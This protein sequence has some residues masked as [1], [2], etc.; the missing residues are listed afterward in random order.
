[1]ADKNI[2]IVKVDPTGFFLQSEENT[3]N[4]DISDESSVS[5]I[6]SG[7]TAESEKLNHLPLVNPNVSVTKEEVKMEPVTPP[8]ISVKTQEDLTQASNYLSTKPESSSNLP[9]NNNTPNS[10]K[11][12][13]TETTETMSINSDTDTD[14]TSSSGDDVI[15][16]TDNALY[17]VLAAVLEDEEGN[18]VTDMLSS[19]NTNL[20][21]H[22]ETLEKILGEYAEINRERTK[23]RR[24]FEQMAMAIN[25]QNRILEKLSNMFEASLKSS[26]TKVKSVDMEGGRMDDELDRIKNREKKRIDTPENTDVKGSKFNLHKSSGVKVDKQD[27]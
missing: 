16:M 13:D 5:S 3:K 15:D 21:K 6:S 12:E 18:N 26:G 25:N 23:E 20:D 14:S 9:F 8:L 17:S 11:N 27:K 24:Y 22:N 4:S 2:K 10:L 7:G 19:I 1:M